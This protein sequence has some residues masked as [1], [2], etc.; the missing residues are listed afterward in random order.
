[1]EGT[2]CKSF[3]MVRCASLYELIVTHNTAHSKLDTRHVPVNGE[4]VAQ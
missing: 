4:A 3:V 2:E 1:M